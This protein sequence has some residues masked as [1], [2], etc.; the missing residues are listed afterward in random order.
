L[1]LGGSGGP[2]GVDGAGEG[3]LVCDV[4]STEEGVEGM[5]PSDFSDMAFR[6]LQLIRP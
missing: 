1:L 4:A 5:F 6:E 3:S 2:A